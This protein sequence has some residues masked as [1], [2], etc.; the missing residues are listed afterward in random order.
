MI[1]RLD[2]PD[3]VFLTSDTH[4][5]HL[6]IIRYCNR[7]WPDVEV[8]NEALVHLW[9]STVPQDATVI[10]LGDVAMG[11]LSDSLQHVRRLNGRKHLIAGN[12]DRCY[13]N[14]GKVQMYLDAGFETVCDRAELHCEG[15]EFDLIHVPF[16][17]AEAPH[18]AERSEYE[19]R[20]LRVPEDTGRTLLCGHVH[21]AWRSIRSGKGTPMFNMGSDVHGFR[22]VGLRE[23]LELTRFI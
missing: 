10:H 14:P 18:E 6:N 17:G 1:F 23:V 7:P 9:N 8:M 19:K 5:G 13:G 4:F 3:G 20:K 22:P 16:P 2:S 15:R 11:R 12:H 21:D